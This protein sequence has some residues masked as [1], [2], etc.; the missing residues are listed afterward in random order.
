MDNEDI[1]KILS[2]LGF[3]VIQTAVGPMIVMSPEE[4]FL[5]SSISG[6]QYLLTP[7]GVSFK[8][9]SEVFIH[10]SVFSD[11]YLIYSPGL[12]SR[13][14]EGFLK[15]ENSSDRLV[16]D[17]PHV[18]NLDKFI[19]IRDINQGEFSNIE[20]SCFKELKSAGL[21]CEDFVLYKNFLYG[22]LDEALLEYLACMEY[23]NQGYM[24]ENQVP[25]F[26]QSYKY[27]GRVLNGGTPDFSAFHSSISSKLDELGIINDNKGIAVNLLP[28]IKLF[29]KNIN[30]ANVV[31]KNFNY[32]LIIGEAKTSRSSALQAVKQL[33]KYSAVDLAEEFYTIITDCENNNSKYGEMFI[34]GH[35][36]VVHKANKAVNLNTS[37]RAEDNHWID[38]YIKM[39]L[40]GNFAFDSI[41]NLIK[42]FRSKNN[43]TLLNNYEACHLLDAVQNI[44]NDEFIE[45]LKEEL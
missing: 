26:Q 37:S 22:G 21:K 8:G 33:D 7:N 44:S 1:L 2:N 25:W 12:F 14:M 19:Y 27:N 5:F 20:N 6:A 10:R 16:S 18:F 9:R 43:L 32:E 29:R 40:L 23:I 15:E 13:T 39:L 42:N 30:L 11:G 24:V 35:R 31:K 28:Y 41:L 34:K 17:Y 4:A 3:K 36:L 38:L 45:L